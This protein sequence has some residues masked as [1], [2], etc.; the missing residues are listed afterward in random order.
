MFI[1]TKTAFVTFLMK[2][3]DSCG[4]P[5]VVKHVLHLPISLSDVEPCL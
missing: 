4:G 1:T 2:Y 5:L 3:V